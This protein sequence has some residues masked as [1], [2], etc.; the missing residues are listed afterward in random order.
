MCA[1]PGGVIARS[2]RQRKDPT[3][4]ELRVAWRPIKVTEKEAAAFKR[5]FKKKARLLLDE[6]LDAA[7]A[8]GLRALGW[9]LE[10]VEEVGL[11]GRDDGDVLAYAH[12]KD[13]ILISNDSGFRDERRFPPQRNP[14]VIILPQDTSEAARSLGVVL[15]IVGE[16]RELFRGD[17]V[18]VDRGGT[19]SVR[20]TKADG[21]RSTTRYRYSNGPYALEWKEE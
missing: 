9:K 19:I 13:R 20:S 18:E 3:P 2:G 15:P 21:R 14:G 11:R 16:Y 4:P 1:A 8:D 5:R 17:V 12:R 6:N 10:T 7:L